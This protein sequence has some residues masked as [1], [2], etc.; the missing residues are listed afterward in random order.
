MNKTKTISVI[1]IGL[2]LFSGS[3]MFLFNFKQPI[4][5]VEAS[6]AFVKVKDGYISYLD[7][8]GYNFQFACEINQI[9]ILESE[10]SI[11]EGQ[12]IV[13]SNNSFGITKLIFNQT[14]SNNVKFAI[15]HQ[16]NFNRDYWFRMH[17]FNRGLT[18]IEDRNILSWETGNFDYSDMIDE[19]FW[20]DQNDVGDY[21]LSLRF[22]DQVDFYI[23]PILSSEIILD[24]T[25]VF[26]Y[27]RT[28]DRDLSKVSVHYNFDYGSGVTIYDQSENGIDGTLIGTPTWEDSLND[29]FDECLRFNSDSDSWSMGDHDELEF[30]NVNGDIPFMIS[31][32]LNR[33]NAAGWIY[34]KMTSTENPISYLYYEAGNDIKLRFRLDNNSVDSGHFVFGE[35]PYFNAPRGSWQHL[36]V[37]YDGSADHSGIEFYL[38]GT[39]ITKT[40][41]NFQNGGTYIGVPYDT[42]Y[43]NYGFGGIDSGDNTGNGDVDEYQIWKD[44][45]PSDADILALFE[46]GAVFFD[47]HSSTETGNWTGFATNGT[48]QIQYNLNY[49]ISDPSNAS[50][51][52]L[53]TYHNHSFYYYHNYTFVNTTFGNGTTKTIESGFSIS[54]ENSTHDKVDFTAGEVDGIYI[55][56]FVT[57]NAIT[58][59]IINPD[60]SNGTLTNVSSVEYNIKVANGSV[61]IPNSPVTIQ[62]LDFAGDSLQ[63][64]SKSTNANGWVNST[65][66]DFQFPH[67]GNNTYWV[68]AISMNQSFVGVMV[69]RFYA[70]N[71]WNEPVINN[72]VFEDILTADTS[73]TL[74]VYVIDDWTALAD[75]TMSMDYSFVSSGT[76]TESASLSLSIDHYT[77]S[78]IGQEAGTSLWFQIT[79]EDN[80]SNSFTSTIYQTDWIIE[81]EG[82]PAGGDGDGNGAPAVVGQPTGG[83]PDVVLILLFGAG[84]VSVAVVGYAVF[85]RVQVRTRRVET[86]EVIT[87]LGTFGRSE[88][89]IV[90]KGR[91][92]KGK[93][94]KKRK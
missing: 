59:L 73:F 22:L 34:G 67:S 39:K 31:F 55:W 27:D 50:E 86:R 83:I 63:S 14:D 74:G 94:K 10:V 18:H 87:G 44:V 6:P 80:M 42:S 24:S 53:W 8:R 70:Y 52:E 78:L 49:T 29:S 45:T 85:Q 23:D 4:I 65:T 28:S 12:I 9:L 89:K 88:E 2:M 57:E 68:R 62:I 36:V 33:V 19:S 38:N 56:W 25:S 15:N 30:G 32:W 17:I 72:I 40:G 92:P 82:T 7:D 75:L 51:D 26:A 91:K 21:W 66:G 71:D 16:G 35:S 58:N 1:M 61:S 76:L 47:E 3:M 81:E 60:E 37:T 64:E 11:Q 90:V 69:K 46:S 54:V 84:A 13:E 93:K 5:L 79:V 77:I 43:G 20:I 41:G 48:S